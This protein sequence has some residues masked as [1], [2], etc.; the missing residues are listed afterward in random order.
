MPDLKTPYVDARVRLLAL[1]DGL[2]D[3]AFNAKPSAKAWS[4][5]ECVVHLNTMA[6]DYLP[7][8]EAAVADP[9]APRGTSPFRYGWAGRQFVKAV[10]PGSRA[11]PTAPAMKPPRAE[12]HRSEIDRDRAVSRFTSDIDRFLAVVDAADGL[13]LARIKLR[14]P[15]AWF[16]KF[17]LGVF[18][19]AMG[20]HSLRHVLQAERAVAA[21][22]GAA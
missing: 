21:T 11:L 12:G 14:S 16:I 15:F 17:P 10:T 20:Q 6:K 8:L 5:G 18:L 13:D 4:A 22:R 7:R 3:D 19:E 2:S 1:V 9:D